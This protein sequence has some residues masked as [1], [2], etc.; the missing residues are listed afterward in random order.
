MRT[1]L[2]VQFSDDGTGSFEGMFERENIGVVYH[3]FLSFLFVSGE[4][5]VLGMSLGL[6]CVPSGI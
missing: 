3:T 1:L 6:F 4:T 2:K 5:F